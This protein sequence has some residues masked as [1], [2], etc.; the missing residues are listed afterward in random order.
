MFG[1]HCVLFSALKWGDS[2]TLVKYLL[3]VLTTRKQTNQNIFLERVGMIRDTS[4]HMDNDLKSFISIFLK[5][6]S[7]LQKRSHASQKLFIMKNC[8]VLKL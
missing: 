4:F 1:L 2:V 5:F 3:C 7:K 8:L 6:S